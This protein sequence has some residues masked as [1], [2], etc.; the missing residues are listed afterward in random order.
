MPALPIVVGAVR[1]ES[2]APGDRRA[3]VA[4]GGAVE[5]ARRG[6]CL[7][8]RHAGLPDALARSVD[9]VIDANEQMWHFFTRF[10]IGGPRAVAR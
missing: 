7:A 4:A 1:A 6:A 10:V 5:T 3:F 2:L 9:E 8:G